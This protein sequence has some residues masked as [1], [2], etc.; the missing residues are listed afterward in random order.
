MMEEKNKIHVMDHVEMVDT[1][2]NTDS[3]NLDTEDKD[4]SMVESNTISI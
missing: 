3:L 1:I 2:P 4:S